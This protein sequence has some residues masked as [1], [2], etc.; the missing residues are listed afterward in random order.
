VGNTAERHDMQVEFKE[1]GQAVDMEQDIQVHLY[2]AARELLVN[3]VKHSRAKKVSIELAYAHGLV[4]LSVADDGKGFDA[5]AAAK[6]ASG[7]FGLFS[8]RERLQPLGG[9]LAIESQPGQ[10]ASISISLP[11]ATA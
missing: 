3:A 4:T 1:Q 9:E 10:G 8:L 5:A 2:R 11:L 6:G 7:G